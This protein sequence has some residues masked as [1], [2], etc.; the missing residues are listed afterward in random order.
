MVCINHFMTPSLAGM[1]RD[2]C[3]G[4]HA[5]QDNLYNIFTTYV[6]S[7]ASGRPACHDQFTGAQKAPKAHYTWT[8]QQGHRGTV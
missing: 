5:S 6:T 4:A 7:L 8:A 1:P 2:A 3:N